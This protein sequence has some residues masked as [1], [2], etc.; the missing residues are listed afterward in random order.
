MNTHLR[1]FYLLLYILAP[2]IPVTTSLF[3]STQDSHNNVIEGRYWKEGDLE[4]KDEWK[5][6]MEILLQAGDLERAK[7]A[8]KR[9]RIW[10]PTGTS[11]KGQLAGIKKQLE[12]VRKQLALLA[13]AMGVASPKQEAEAKRVIN[14]NKV[15][16]EEEKRK[17]AEGK[18]IK[19]MKKEAKERKKKEE[20]ALK[21]Y[22]KLAV[23]AQAIKEV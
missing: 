17:E 11:K 1:Q 9:E 15:M 4:G 14:S 7:E 5:V 10:R 3:T 23:Q 19:E 12:K 13:A 16:V 8:S 20:E 21:K 6:V 22:K 18:K 2:L